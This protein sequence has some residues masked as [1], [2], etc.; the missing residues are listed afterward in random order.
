MMMPLPLI[1][2]DITFYLVPANGP[3]PYLASPLHVSNFAALQSFDPS[4][5][6]TLQWDPLVGASG[7]SFIVVSVANLAGQY[8]FTSPLPG[9][10]GVLPGTAT[11]VTVPPGTFPATTT[12]HL[13]VPVEVIGEISGVGSNGRGDQR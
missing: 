6:L 10:P 12:L 3:D 13:A 9:Q 7:N 8:L 11:S 1:A 5:P 4:R 2:G